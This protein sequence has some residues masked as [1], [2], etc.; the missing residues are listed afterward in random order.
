MMSV[1]LAIIVVGA[2]IAIVFWIAD[3]IREEQAGYVAAL[4]RRIADLESRLENTRAELNELKREITPRQ[5][6]THFD[7]NY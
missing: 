5:R 6:P 7:D 4:R 2:P 3:R 1:W